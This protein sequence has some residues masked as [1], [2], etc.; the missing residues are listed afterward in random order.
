MSLKSTYKSWRTR[1][2]DGVSDG[3]IYKGETIIFSDAVAN[4]NG[5]NLEKLIKKYDLGR[6]VK[7]STQNPNTN[8][9]ITTYLW[10][11]NGKQIPEKKKVTT[12]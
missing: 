11:Y 7:L 4:G 5:V 12:K 6:V 1:N 2:G 10:C 8:N 9:R 3:R